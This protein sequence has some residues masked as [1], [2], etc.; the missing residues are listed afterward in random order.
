MTRMQPMMIRLPALLLERADR[1]VEPLV[2]APEGAAVGNVTRA[3]VLRLAIAEGL[4][5]LEGRFGTSAG[6]AP[7]RQPPDRAGG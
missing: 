6:E 7:D 5:V 4:A 3:T 1:L 2:T